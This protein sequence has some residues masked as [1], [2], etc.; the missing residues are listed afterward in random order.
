MYF[1][2]FNY[3]IRRDH[4]FGTGF[5]SGSGLGRVIRKNRVIPIFPDRVKLNNEK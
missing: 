3:N 5:C 4:T 1:N 2:K